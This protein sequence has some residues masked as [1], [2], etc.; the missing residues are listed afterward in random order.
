MPIV[1][2]SGSKTSKPKTTS[3]K[4][5]QSSEN[6]FLTDIGTSEGLRAVIWGME[7][8]GKSSLLAY[9]PDVVFITGSSDHGIHTLHKRGLVPRDIRIARDVT[10]FDDAIDQLQTLAAMDD[11][12]NVAVDCGSIL[13]EMCFQKCCNREYRGDYSATGFFSFYQGPAT[14][15]TSD[16]YWPSLIQA[17]TEVS[18]AGKNIFLVLHG[19]VNTFQNPEGPDYDQYTPDLD[20]RIWQPTAKWADLILFVKHNVEVS[21]ESNTQKKF[22]GEGGAER[23]IC[24]ERTAAYI[25]KNRHNLP[26]IIGPSSDPKELQRELWDN[27]FQKP[28]VAT[29]KPKKKLTVRR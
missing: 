28:K 14:A 16:L 8:V 21:K 13:Q 4:K 27:L 25:A 3:S 10:D 5:P 20:K 6:L 19:K 11:V 7:G 29:A 22:K 1:R 12:Q 24:T 18:S 23:V 9:A 2:R 15:A 17:M 26:S